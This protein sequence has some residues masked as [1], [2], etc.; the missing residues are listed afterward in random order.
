MKFKVGDKVILYDGKTGVISD[1]E[2]DGRR[3][4]VRYDKPI[5]FSSEGAGTKCPG[6][7]VSAIVWDGNIELDIARIRADKLKEIL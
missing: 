4:R 1:I 6:L 3:Y 2:W 7:I 5:K